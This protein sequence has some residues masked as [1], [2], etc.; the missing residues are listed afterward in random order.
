M[1]QKFFSLIFGNIA[2]N[3]EFIKVIFFTEKYKIKKTQQQKGHSYLQCLTDGVK[4]R[5][6]SNCTFLHLLQRVTD[7]V[8]A[9]NNAG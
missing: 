1:P 9:S 8:N 3:T 2:Q 7:D 5:M 6:I 4:A